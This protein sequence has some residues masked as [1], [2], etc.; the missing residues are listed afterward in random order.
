[1]GGGLE[2]GMRGTSRIIHFLPI[3]D[4]Y[5]VENNYIPTSVY[6]RKLSVKIVIFDACHN[7]DILNTFHILFPLNTDP[8]PS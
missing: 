1:M 8:T 5:P 7:F 3:L 6:V 4:T 2:A